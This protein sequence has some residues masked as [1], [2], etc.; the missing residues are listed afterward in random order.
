VQIYYLCINECARHGYRCVSI[1]H[2]DKNGNGS[3]TRLT[4]NKCCGS[5]SVLRKWKLSESEWKKLAD[6][7][8]R[9]QRATKR[10]LQSADLDKHAEDGC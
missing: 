6:E 2:L 9:A 10:Q 3:G 5:W 7:A 8:R 4:P 1:D